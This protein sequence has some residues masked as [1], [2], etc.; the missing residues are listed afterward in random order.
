[1]EKEGRR[2]TFVSDSIFLIPSFH[3]WKACF[4]P[5][6]CLRLLPPF[7]S[8]PLPRVIFNRARHRSSRTRARRE[9]QEEKDGPAVSRAS[10]MRRRQIKRVDSW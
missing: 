7:L 2:R 10:R 9:G 3:F 8:S 1:M 5:P 6:L 4:P